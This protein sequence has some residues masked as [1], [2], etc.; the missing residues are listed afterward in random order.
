MTT[1]VTVTLHI[2]ADDAHEW[3]DKLAAFA[4]AQSGVKQV[5]ATLHDGTK[6]DQ[7]IKDF[8]EMYRLPVLAKPG[9]PRLE[10][11]GTDGSIRAQLIEY[12]NKFY[13]I[14]KEELE[15]VHAIQTGIA[16]FSSEV[17]VLTELADWLGDIQVYCASEMAKFGLPNSEILDIIMASNM[18]KL[19]ED[20]KPIYDDR[21]KVLK[22]PAYW[23]P[24]PRIAELI[25]ERLKP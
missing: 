9:I 7:Q 11:F 19:G 16:Q 14:L 12:L 4:A 24:E 23:K 8:N 22:G 18:S 3:T 20:G 2:Q 25:K 21:G 15:E 13:S 1:N 5:T 10:V 17:D 6:F